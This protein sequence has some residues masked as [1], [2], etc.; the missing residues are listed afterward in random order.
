MMVLYW[1][2][3][4]LA[5]LAETMMCC[6]FSK[7]FIENEKNNRIR[8]FI[9]SFFAATLVM[10]VNQIDL[11]SF[12]N[13]ILGI[14]MLFI[15]QC[16]VYKRSYSLLLLLTLIFSV[17][18]SAIDFFVV[19]MG[20]IVWNS[21]T[22]YL[23]ENQSVERCYCVVISKIILFSLIYF[24]DK[25]IRNKMELPKRYTLAICFMALAL[26]TLDYYIIG[27]DE[28][29]V[30]AEIRTFSTIFF[31][32]SIILII[33]FFSLILKLAENYKQKEDIALLELQ[34]EMILKS[35]KNTEQAFNLWRSSI[36]DYKHK[37]IA[38][39]YWL[40]EGNVESVKEFIDKESENLT[41]KVF[42]IKTGNDVVD[43]IV[44]TKQ[45]L[46]EE[47][48]IV[49]AMNI[50]VPASCRVS[51]IDLVCILGNLIDNAI[52]ACEKQEKKHIDVIIKEVKKLLIIKVINSY[53][54][55]LKEEPL[56]TKKEKALHGIGLRNVKNIVDKYDGTYEMIQ[57]EDEVITTIMILNKV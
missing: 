39:K 45:K 10:I 35:E 19:Q 6:L 24:I 11:F 31:V 38:I 29:T 57:D 14:I 46:A 49:F 3:D 36:H 26:V 37:I 20:A 8:I 2:V 42:Y 40:D 53:E 41:Q 47:K 30:N 18:D 51:D 7:A 5:T 43:A 56:T 1:S 13:G 48:N 4:Y 50:A 33:V 32:V 27:K 22:N 15:L 17:I 23:L 12:A 44:N 52:E 16:L 55:R 34:N 54:E 25:Y 21:T 9:Y 28:I